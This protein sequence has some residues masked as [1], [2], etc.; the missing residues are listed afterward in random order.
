[1]VF[2]HP[3]Q[4]HLFLQVGYF[5]DGV[6]LG[7]ALVGVVGQAL[8]CNH[9]PGDALKSSLGGSAAHL[10]CFGDI[11]AAGQV[12]GTALQGSKLDAAGLGVQLAGDHVGQIPGS[13]GQGFVAKGVHRVHIIRQ[14]TDIA[15]VLQLDAL[16]NSDHDAGLGLL[17][18][19]DLF[20]KTVHIERH[21]R[22]ADHIHAFTVIAL[23]QG[24]GGGQPAGVAAHDLHN[25]DIFGAVDRSIP[26]DLLHYHTN[27]LGRRAI[28]G[29]VVSDHQIVVDGLGHAY[30]PDIAVDTGA[31]V[32]QLADGIHGVVAADVEEVAHIQLVQDRKQLF[33]DRLILPPIRQLIAAAAQKAGRG[34]LQ[35][36]DVQVIR[37]VLGQIHD[38]LLQKPRYTIAH[39]VHDGCAAV[40]ATFKHTGQA[41]IDD[42]GGAA[43]LTN[44]C[45]L[46]HDDF[47][48]FVFGFDRL[49]PARQQ[50]GGT[51]P[52]LRSCRRTKTRLK[53]W[54]KGAASGRIRQVQ[55]GIKGRCDG[56]CR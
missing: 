15:A 48:F 44:D 40:F 18:G 31:V 3:A 17:H 20:D 7:G 55:N 45:V 25:G 54:G 36:L 37:E 47:S 12:T 14:L 32:C 56:G 52:L 11:G 51:E 10:V 4:G 28:A 26:D 8:Q 22:Q 49:Y 33:V 38:P 16:G 29:G 9:L 39:T 41:C 5:A 50:Q 42:R 34:A 53:G 24:S 35:Q 27:V 21:F 1:M 2:V 19:L 43:G 13:A 46:T 30:E 23:G 6:Q